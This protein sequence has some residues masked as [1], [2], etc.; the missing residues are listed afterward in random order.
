M[1]DKARKSVVSAGI[2][3]WRRRTNCEFLLAHP[4][5]PYWAK[6]DDR[7]WTVPKGLVEAGDDLEETAKRE[8]LE[9]TGLTVS[10][11]LIPLK[12]AKSGN[13]KIV[14]VFALEAD[15]DPTEFTSNNFSLEWPPRSGRMLEFPEIDRLAYFGYRE[16]LNKIIP[17]Q[18]ALIEQAHGLCGAGNIP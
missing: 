13:G 6:K 10:G 18:R 14:R 4:G 11:N 1:P 2:L 5:G 12:P 15:L 16:A 8:F 17:Y 3:V 7:A 9:E